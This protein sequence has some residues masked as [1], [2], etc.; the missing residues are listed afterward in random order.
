M[1]GLSIPEF[2]AARTIRKHRDGITAAVD[3]G[4][5]NGRQEELNNKVDS[6]SVAPAASTVQSRATAML[7]C[8]PVNLQLPCHTPPPT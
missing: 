7:A 2:K 1:A 4:L 3:R 5:A 6:S 8:G